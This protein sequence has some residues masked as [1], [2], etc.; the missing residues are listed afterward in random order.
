[1]TKPYA[2]TLLIASLLLAGCGGADSKDGKDDSGKKGDDPKAAAAPARPETVEL[3]DVD[4]A[5]YEAEIAKLKGRVVL[6]D[7]WAIWCTE[8]L[9]AFP[10]TLELAE[11]HRDEGLT[12]VT[13]SFDDDG[14]RAKA[15][16]FLGKKD[17]REINLRVKSGSSEESFEQWGIASGTLPHIKIYG[18]DGKVAKTLDAGTDL[19]AASFTHEDVAKAVEEVLAAE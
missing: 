16:E 6:V 1:M 9:K 5:E 2:L 11:E 13:L 15:L 4:F 12:L 8:C 7:C 14:A 17:A 10:H 19:D 18:R 3:K